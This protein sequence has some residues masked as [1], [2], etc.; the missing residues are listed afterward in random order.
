MNSSEPVSRGLMEVTLLVVVAVCVLLAIAV[1]AAKV[2]LARRAEATRR[3]L[4]PL[5][6]D[7]L[8]VAAGEDP[9]G[10]GRARLMAD[11]DAGP[12]LDRALIGLL[13]K[14][15]G[16]P[17]EDLVSVLRER[18]VEQ[19]ALA[20]L[21]SISSVRRARATRALGL[22][23]DPAHTDAILGRLRD[24]SGEVRLVAA[25][26]LGALGPDAGPQAATALLRSV[27]T[28]SGE[29]GVPA[30]AAIGALCSL[31]FAAEP[32]VAAGMSDPD[33]GVRHVA[34]SV[35]GHNLF[36][37]C[38]DRLAELAATDHDVA[39]RVSATAALGR[40]GRSGDM[41]AV[42]ALLAAH[43]PASVRRAAA[44]ALGSIGTEEAG[45]VLVGMLADDDR[46]LALAAAEA[47]A[48]SGLGRDLLTEVAED[49]DAAPAARRAAEGALQVL[50][51]QD[52]SAGARG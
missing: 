43:E 45:E 30:T 36:L 50:R 20:A 15:R 22:L 11:R 38:G 19:R 28:V 31:G 12:A 27:R 39:V 48:G 9:D 49:Q 44:R 13:T 6:A 24:R 26:A 34:A 5:R 17:G 42:A 41:P 4:A 40:F 16:T 47:L 18:D 35:A 25:R 51:L 1:V 7:L 46:A 21:D 3:T 52:E 29:P 2:V 33:P 37:R 14:V 10:A 23:R 8:A 32:A